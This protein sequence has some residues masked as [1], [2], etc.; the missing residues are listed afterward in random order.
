MVLAGEKQGK[1]I[2]SIHSE[3]EEIQIF[4][5][6]NNMIIYGEFIKIW[7]KIYEIKK[8]IVN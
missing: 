6:N 7:N 5:F 8:S 4:L 1:Y 3:N 2:K